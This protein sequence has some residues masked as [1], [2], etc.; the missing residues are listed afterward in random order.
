MKLSVCKKWVHPICVMFTSEL[1]VNNDMRACNLEALDPDR[2]ILV[3]MVCRDRVGSSVQCSEPDCLVSAHAC[4]ALKSDFQMT[5]RLAN[6]RNGDDCNLQCNIYCFLH[7]NKYINDDTLISCRDR[8]YLEYLEGRK[9][10]ENKR[11]EVGE[12]KEIVRASPLSQV[13]AEVCISYIAD[14][15][16]AY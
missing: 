8:N 12:V 14:F 7:F 13:F 15:N 3:C 4:C 1:T 6:S 10:T 2:K 16:G 9:A 11:G 5:V